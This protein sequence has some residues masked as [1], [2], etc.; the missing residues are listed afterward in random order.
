MINVT[1]AELIKLI[2]FFVIAVPKLNLETLQNVYI[3]R[4]QS[5]SR[6]QTTAI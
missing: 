4:N 3:I 2:G 1:K 6:L 5:L